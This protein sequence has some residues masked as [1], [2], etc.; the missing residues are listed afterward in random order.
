MRPVLTPGIRALCL[1]SVQGAEEG[2]ARGVRPCRVQQHH[3]GVRRQLAL[4]VAEESR[5]RKF[6][7]Y[8]KYIV[9]E[10]SRILHVLMYHTCAPPEPIRVPNRSIPVKQRTFFIAQ[11][12]VEFCYDCCNRGLADIGRA[13]RLPVEDVVVICGIPCSSTTTLRSAGSR[14]SAGK[15][16]AHTSS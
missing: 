8:S 13:G 5:R 16:N 7:L 1:V 10:Y 6:A 2:G 15:N 3:V 11:I 9:F 4:L 12:I 14:T